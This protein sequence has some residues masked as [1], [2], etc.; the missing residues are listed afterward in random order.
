MPDEPRAP[1]AERE[2]N[3]HLLLPREPAQQKQIADV[4]ARNQED[5]DDDDERDAERRQKRA[6]V[7]ERRLPERVQPDAAAAVRLRVL[8]LETRRD[9]RHL[10]LRLLDRHAGLEPQVAFDPAGAA[11]LELV[12]A[13]VE[14]PLH[15]GRHPELKRVADERAVEALRRHADDRVR[16]AGEHL[17]FAD[18][19][20]IAAE[21]VLPRL[22]ADHRHRMRVA[23]GVLARVESAAENRTHADRVEV[24]RRDHAARRALGAIA[25]AER[26]PRDFL[27]D[28]RVGERA[29]ALKI[30]PVGPRHVVPVRARA[31]IGAGHRDEAVLIDHER[32]RPQQDAFDPAEHGGV[33]ADAEREAERRE[34]GK[35]GI[36]PQH[37]QRVRRVAANVVDPAKH[38]GVPRA[39][40][41]ECHSAEPRERRAPRRFGSHAAPDVVVGSLGDVEAPLLVE[42]PLGARE[43]VSQAAD[44]SHRCP[45]REA[46]HLAD[47][48][49]Q[50]FP[51]QLLF[52]EA[53]QPRARQLVD[54]RAPVVRRRLPVGGDPAQMLHA[55]ERGIERALLD[56]EDVAGD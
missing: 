25:D 13:G 9:A 20:G 33:G 30:D 1:D 48:L 56:A 6:R 2:A 55:M 47:A 18:D 52:V 10:R 17:R 40:L 27:G 14:L 41:R 16:Q 42:V 8:G 32:I 50:P 39:F 15:R 12:D 51:A 37:A 35:P 43:R 3:R 29:A 19:V 44:P 11:I 5:R 54:P 23:T 31:A 34:Q 49:R 7:V 36:A 28:E 21:A 24:V 38:V 4:G 46:Q 22:V 26:R 53:L 45:L